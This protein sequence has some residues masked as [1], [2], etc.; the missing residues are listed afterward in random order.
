MSQINTSS[1]Y[2]HDNYYLSITFFVRQY[3]LQIIDFLYR[4]DVTEIRALPRVC[5]VSVDSVLVCEDGLVIL[6]AVGKVGSRECCLQR[7]RPLPAR[8]LDP[9][10]AGD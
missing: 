7:A 2:H 10:R 8:A 1:I 5:L 3:S 9:L 6:R 4:Y